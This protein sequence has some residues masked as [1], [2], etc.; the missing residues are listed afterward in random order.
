MNCSQTALRAILRVTDG[1]LRVETYGLPTVSSEIIMNVI[2]ET[3]FQVG[4]Q[5]RLHNYPRIDAAQDISIKLMGQLFSRS[6][7][8]ISRSGTQTPLA[9]V[10]EL[11]SRN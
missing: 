6:L 3:S 8:R 2:V 10:F 11:T 9:E 5:D 4:S 7:H 1:T